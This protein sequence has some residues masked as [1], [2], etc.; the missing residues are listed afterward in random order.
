MISNIAITCCFAAFLIAIALFAL[1]TMASGPW[2]GK[3]GIVCL[4][5]MFISRSIAFSAQKTS[6]AV[7]ALS[8]L[9]A[10]IKGQKSPVFKEEEPYY[11]KLLKK[12]FKTTIAKGADFIRPLK[13]QV[14]TRAFRIIVRIRTNAR[15]YRNARRPVFAHSSHD[16]G[17]G[18][19]GDDSGDSDSGDPPGS[20]HHTAP[21]KLFQTSRRESNNLSERRRFSRAT[22]C[23]RM[24]RFEISFHGRCPA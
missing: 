11:A 23:C 1:C 24:P 9:V 14:C 8:A 16:G 22:G 10:W 4:N 2:V 3:C 18:R 21:L 20:S 12:A 13:A 7:R 5:A 19:S 17:G 15:A 6:Q